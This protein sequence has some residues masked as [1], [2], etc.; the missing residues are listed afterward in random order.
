MLDQPLAP[1]Q[2]RDLQKR[3][4][5]FADADRSIN[6]PSRVMRLPGTIHPQ[7]GKPCQ[8]ANA[9]GA[10]YS[11]EEIS[12][13]IAKPKELPDLS[14]LLSR[15]QEQLVEKGAQEGDRNSQCFRLAVG[16][17]AVENAARAAGIKFSGCSEE[18]VR[19]FEA[20]CEPRL[21]EDELIKVLRSAESR[22]PEPDPGTIN[23]PV[24][25]PLFFLRFS[26]YFFTLS[27]CIPSNCP[28]LGALAGRPPVA[29]N[30]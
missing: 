9:A 26:R 19:Q 23:P 20:R 2:W 25:L 12:K 24:R 11:V 14:N 4:L 28:P 5:N 6:N 21:G 16:T 30:P 3:L 27:D 1:E 17:I 10:R 8:I 15:D 18:I 7:T 22:S 13:A 29:P